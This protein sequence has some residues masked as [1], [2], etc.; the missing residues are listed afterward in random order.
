MLL[1]FEKDSQ[2]NILFS[3][4]SFSN[5]QF[6]YIKVALINIIKVFPVPGLPARIKFL[7]VF[8]KS[9]SMFE[10]IKSKKLLIHISSYFK[11]SKLFILYKIFS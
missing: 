8:I 2:F 1:R 6:K 5:K 3:N 4:F 11:L 10:G 7:L 9:F